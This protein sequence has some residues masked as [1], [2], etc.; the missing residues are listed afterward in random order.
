MMVFITASLIFGILWSHFKMDVQGA[1]GV[2][3]YVVSACGVFVSYL[4][5]KTEKT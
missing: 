4:A 5:V 3:A 1:F 2:S